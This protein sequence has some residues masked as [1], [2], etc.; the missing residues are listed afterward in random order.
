MGA[1]AGLAP[2]GP[3]RAEEPAGPGAP[4]VAVAGVE[5]P[6]G[7]WVFPHVGLVRPAASPGTADDAWALRR[8]ASGRWR[9][10]AVD[11]YRY[12]RAGASPTPTDP[13]TFVDPRTGWTVGG[14]VLDTG[15]EEGLPADVTCASR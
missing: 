13:V 12:V 15:F 9:G 2:R 6:D 5:L 1:L 11:A 8:T 14:G 10:T 4:A 7:T 3:A